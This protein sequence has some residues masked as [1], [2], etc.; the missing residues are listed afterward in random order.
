[1]SRKKTRKLFLL[2]GTALAYRSHFAFVKRPLLNSQ[3]RNVGAIFAYTGTLMR[4]LRDENPDLIAVAFDRPE[5]TFRHEKF[6]EYKAT[7]DKTPDE[8]VEQ[9]PDVKAITEAL[10]VRLVE[11]AGWEADDLIGTLA[12]RGAGEGYDVYI[13]AGDKD[14][15]QLVSDKVRIF[16]ITRADSDVTVQGVDAVQDKFGVPPEGVVDVLGLMGDSSD[17]VP[18]VPGVGVKTAIRLIVEYGSME[19]VYQNLDQI[20]SAALREKLEQ[21]RDLAF[22][23]R[24]LVVIDCAAPIETDLENLDLSAQDTAFLQE[25]FIEFEFNTYISYLDSTGARDDGAHTYTLVDDAAASDDL[26]GR[27]AAARAFAFDTETT[28]LNP[29]QAE[30]VGISVA[31]NEREAF[32]IPASLPGRLFEGGSSILDR[33]L[34]GFAPLLADPNKEVIGQNLKYDLAVL[35]R[36]GINSINARLFDT[37]VAHY[38]CH[39]GEMQH[40]LD[41]LSLK[42][43]GVKKIPTTD[44]IGKGKKQIS[45]ADVPVDKVCGY[46]C[47][48]VDMTLRLRNIFARDLDKMDLTGLFYELEMP[49]LLVLEEMEHK[50]LRV[51]VKVLDSLQKEYAERVTELTAKI[52]ELAGEEFN[53]NSTQQLGK[54]LF[55]KLEVHKEVGLKRVRKT[56]TGYSTNAAVLESISAHPLG[57]LLLEYRRLQ[58]LNSTYVEAL[59]R[60]IEKE[61]GCIHTSFNQ[62]VAATGR[63]SSSDPN[64]QN[65]PIRTPEGKRIREAFVPRDE[66]WQILSADYSQVELRILAHISGDS[67]LQEAFREGKDIHSGTASLIFGVPEDAVTPELRAQ[68]K[69]INFGI[70]YGMGPQ[71]LA[72]ETGISFAE[73]KDFIEAYFGTFPGVKDYIDRTLKEARETGYVTTLLGRKRA[74]DDMDAMNQMVRANMENVAV[75]TP[76]QGTAADLIKKAMLT[77][78][79]VLADRGLRAL[80][81]LQVHDELVFDVPG[82][83]LDTVGELVKLEMESAMDL[84]VPLVVDIGWGNNWREAH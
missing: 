48:D 62:A 73:A 57:H 36:A 39:P 28:S 65:I 18:G 42:Y 53:I 82:D 27:L 72:R 78:P 50:G 79:K 37:M 21:N 5:P 11:K 4:I 77:I 45:M 84:D 55:D 51:D 61:T 34:E 80:M 35:R 71:R 6:P 70:I 22:L 60:L 33:F 75:N 23:S 43:L 20:K 63:L 66:G 40:G 54:I 38:L 3:G 14:F 16:N 74:I 52:Y 58:K 17:N 64:L 2:D 30:I 41:F 68:A 67:Q 81:V 24:E 26:L 56:K 76:I 49:L 69:T 44:L 19:G 83:E 46:A 25:K 1:M 15:M 29:R 32:Y 12:A 10:G 8:L 59:P 47:E 7:R 31:I 13:V 9:L